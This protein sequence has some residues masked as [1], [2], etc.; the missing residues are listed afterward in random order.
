MNVR[1]TASHAEMKKYSSPMQLVVGPGGGWNAIH[2]SGDDGTF[3]TLNLGALGWSVARA[4]R[5]FSFSA[6]KY[7][8]VRSS[9]VR[10]QA[11][12]L[13]DAQSARGRR[14]RSKQAPNR[15]VLHSG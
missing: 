6:A 3:R 15:H 10:E 7:L 4:G 14:L 12:V 5:A 1:A 8:T 13:P 9:G 2:P 11:L